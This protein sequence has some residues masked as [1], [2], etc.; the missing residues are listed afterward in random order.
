MSDMGE[1]SCFVLGFSEAV[2]KLVSVKGLEC[3][4]ISSSCCV[5]I[6]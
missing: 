4:S 5:R 3:G 2:A 6:Q 1:L